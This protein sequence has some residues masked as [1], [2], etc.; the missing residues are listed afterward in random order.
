MTHRHS[1]AIKAQAATGRPRL[2]RARHRRRGRSSSST[3]AA[4]A[5]FLIVQSIPALVADPRG[6]SDP[7]RRAS[8]PTSARSSSAPS[9]PR[10]S[11][12]SWPCPISH[13]H[14]AL[15]LALRAAPP[16]PGPRL[17]HRP[18]RRRAVGR[19]RPLGHRA[20][21]PPPCSRSTPGSP[22]T[23]AGSRSSPARSRA[24]AARSS[25]PRI[26]LAVMVLPIITA[27]CREVFLQTP[28]LHEEAA[29]ALGAT[30]W[31]M[32]RMAVLPVRPL[33]HHLGRRCSASAARSARRWPSP[34]CS[35]PRRHHLQLLTLGE[36]VDDRREH[37]PQLPR[38]VRH[39]T[40][41]CS[42]RPASCSS[43]SP[44][45]STRSPAGSST[46]ARNSRER[47]DDHDDTPEPATSRIRSELAHRGPPARRAAPWMILGAQLAVV[48]GASS[49]CIG[50][51]RRRRVQHGS[52]P[53][54]SAPLLYVVVDLRASRCS[55]R[56]AARRPTASSPR[57]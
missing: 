49:A 44:S 17:H 50:R 51:W 10:P 46:A 36:P 28:V 22:R 53:S 52:A 41:T 21:S 11:R 1:T 37:R 42:S 29:L 3:L 4:V 9:G 40:S 38:G 8:G 14:R 26:V 35:P 18:A 2:L 25:P 48:V 24:P 54:S 27:I 47:T 20:C 39:R 56:A 57:S 13:R 32:I 16:R 43:S 34:W 7:R 23:S 5:V 19:V 6:A 12:S 45:W 15:H 30:R 55:S 31:E 33:R